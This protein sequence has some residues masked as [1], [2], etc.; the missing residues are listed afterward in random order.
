MTD[1]PFSE[2]G[3]EGIEKEINALAESSSFIEAFSLLDSEINRLLTAELTVVLKKCSG[4]DS[5]SVNSLTK[6]ELDRINAGLM[7][8]IL[9]L[10]GVFAKPVFSRIEHFKSIR[11]NVVHEFDEKYPSSAL[12]RK[13]VRVGVD[14]EFYDSALNDFEVQQK[15]LNI[16]DTVYGFKFPENP[17]DNDV[18]KLDGLCTEIR[19]KQVK[20]AANEEAL[21]LREELRKGLE[22]LKEMWNTG[23]V[24][25]TV[26]KQEKELQDWIDKKL[27][28]SESKS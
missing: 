12:Y 28:E 1:S 6:K 16:L 14:S 18:K 3:V 20:D 27:K 5:G 26:Q 19:M 25:K 2:F 8:K 23:S 15:A 9:S 13:Y 7:L 24:G 17:S 4:A 11:N 10:F 22:L 21:L